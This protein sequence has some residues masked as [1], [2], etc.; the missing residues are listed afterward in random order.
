[1]TREI[2]RPEPGF[3]KLRMVSAGPFVPAIIYRTCHCTVNG[4]DDSAPHPWRGTCDRYPRLEAEINGKSVEVLRVWQSGRPIDQAE[5]EYLC[6]DREW[7]H[8]HAPARLE[9]ATPRDYFR[10]DLMKPIF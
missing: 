5:H 9:A 10:V 3:F 6:A 4:G 2:D 1:M 7:C 8:R